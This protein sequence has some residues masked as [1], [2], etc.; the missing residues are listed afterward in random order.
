MFFLNF[1]LSYF[2]CCLPLGLILYD[3]YVFK[4]KNALKKGDFSSLSVCGLCI[5][6]VWKARSSHRHSCICTHCSVLP[7]CVVVRDTLWISVP[8][9]VQYIASKF[10]LFYKD[11]TESEQVCLKYDAGPS[12]YAAW[13]RDF[14]YTAGSLCL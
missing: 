9:Q 7:V 14:A 2:A 1:F 11:N 8:T 6:F 5:E 3:R 10:P 13:E 4:K 12:Y